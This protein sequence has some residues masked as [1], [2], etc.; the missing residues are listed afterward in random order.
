MLTLNDLAQSLS[1]GRTTS[2]A[3]TEEALARIDDSDGEGARVFIE[4]YREQALA[5]AEASDR[6]R[7]FGIVPSPLAGIPISIKDL[8]DVAGE[9]TRAGSKALAEAPPARADAPVVARLRA[10]GAVIVGRTNMSEF[11]YSGIGLN[12]HYGTPRNPWDR[13]TG[14]VPGGSSSGA[15]VS[16]ADG[17]AAMGLGSDTAGSVR[18][19]AA[20]CGLTG[21]KPTAR[22]VPLQGAYPLSGT[23]DSIGPLAPSVA[24]CS[25]VDAILAGEPPTP[26]E[27]RALAGMRLLAPDNYL[28]DDLDEGVAAAYGRALSA[29]SAAGAS[30]DEIPLPVLDDVAATNITGGFATVEAYAVHRHLMAEKGELYDQMVLSRMQLG[31]EVSAADY[32]DLLAARADQ[33]ARMDRATAPYDALISPTVAMVAPPLSAVAEDGEFRR[34]NLLALRNCRVANFLDRCAITLPCQAEGEAPVGLMLMGETMGDQ[35]LLEVAAAIEEA[36]TAA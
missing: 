21:F 30:I 19:P 2:R 6:A 11:A 32:L 36:L 7:G 29:L 1:A 17:M 9:V 10:A 27:P 8:F 4:V 3:L 12:P 22:R 28:L 20:F 24:C 5:A 35:A 16:V 31:A 18:L 13:A 26:L 23:L 33:R 34:L 15:A 25:L 14:R